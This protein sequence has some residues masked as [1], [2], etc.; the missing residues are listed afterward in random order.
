MKTTQTASMNF[1]QNRDGIDIL[2][3]L[4][5]HPEIEVAARKYDVASKACLRASHLPP[6]S[7][8]EG[9]RRRQHILDSARNTERA[10]CR[11]YEA[12]LKRAGFRR[13]HTLSRRLFWLLDCADKTREKSQKIRVLLE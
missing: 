13:S 6:E 11:E 8:L 9:H 12:E 10:A 3:Y 7:T 4:R 1:L 5:F 2:H